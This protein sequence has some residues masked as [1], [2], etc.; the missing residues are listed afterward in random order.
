MDH[1]ITTESYFHFLRPLLVTIFFPS[2]YWCL[3]MCMT[4]SLFQGCLT[5]YLYSLQRMRFCFWLGPLHCCNTNNKTR[6][7][8]MNWVDDYVWVLSRVFYMILYYMTSKLHMYG[9]GFLTW[10]YMIY[11][12]IEC[13]SVI[14]LVICTPHRLSTAKTGYDSFTCSPTEIPVYDCQNW[15]FSADEPTVILVTFGFP[16][17]GFLEAC[18]VMCWFSERKNPF[19]DS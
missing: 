14:W 15:L 16:L 6:A 18:F 10:S 11:F 8:T 3:T 1:I 4:S 2:A 12:Y 5:R 17:E 13:V 9:L 19:K 7:I